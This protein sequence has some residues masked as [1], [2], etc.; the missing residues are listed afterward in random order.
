VLEQIGGHHRV[1]RP[2]LGHGRRVGHVEGQLRSLPESL[3]R[4]LDHLRAGVD[5]DTRLDTEPAE[6]LTCTATHIEHAARVG[7]H[8]PADHTVQRL[9][10]HVPPGF[11]LVVAVRQGIPMLPGGDWINSAHLAITQVVA[12]NLL[13]RPVPRP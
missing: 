13:S 3:P 9:G 5:A 1:E 12:G 11:G 2:E 4:L 10:I 7:R 8:R 6:Q